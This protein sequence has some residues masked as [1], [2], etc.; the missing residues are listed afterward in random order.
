MRALAVLLLLTAAQAQAAPRA[1]ALFGTEKTPLT[2]PAEPIGTYARGCAAGNVRLPDTGPTWQVMRPARDRAWGN[3]VTIRFLEDLSR[4]AAT[5]PGWKGLYI[6]DIGQPRGGPMASGH[7]S[8]QIGLDADVWFLP[9][10]SLTLSAASRDR[11]AAISV[12]SADQRQVTGAFTPA[13]AA[14]LKHAAA[15]PRVDRIFVAA[16]IKKALCKTAQ[17]ADTPWLQKL[18]PWYGHED[19]FHVRLKCPADETT[20]QPQRPTVAEL[21]HGG[22]GCDADLDWWLTTYLDELK[23]PPPPPRAPK[24]RERGPRDFLLS[25][26]PARCAAVLTPN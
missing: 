5:E 21:S 16:A 11:I 24:P 12:R 18:R 20:C 19:H 10:T 1:T 23:H 2:G 14:I 26:L 22:N 8:H 15:D 7:A 17:P 6:G 13:T 9:A 3:P 25:D 4:F